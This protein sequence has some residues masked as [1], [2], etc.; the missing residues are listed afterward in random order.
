MYRYNRRP[1]NS[2]VDIISYCVSDNNIHQKFL[3]GDGFG[4]E[5]RPCQK[6][7]AQHCAE[8]WDLPCDMALARA[9]NSRRYH[10]AQVIADN[11]SFMSPAEVLVRNTAIEKYRAATRFCHYHE[12]QFDP[13]NAKSPMLK[14]YRGKQCLIYLEVKDPRAIDADPVMNMLLQNP[15]VSAD[16][17][18]N[19]Q[20]TMRAKG[21]L[22]SL[23]GTRLGRFYGVGGGGGGVT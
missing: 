1:A 10:V 22:A 11:P 12:E 23:R 20:S 9:N 19:I 15:R 3:H 8:R 2:D 17:L 5:S 14:H 18:A 13:N 16:I 21:T 6:L 4:Q 7:L